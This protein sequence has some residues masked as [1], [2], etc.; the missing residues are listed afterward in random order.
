MSSTLFKDEPHEYW[1]GGYDTIS[2]MQIGV[3][4]IDLYL[5]GVS[6][7]KGKR[8]L[9]KGLI[10]RLHQEF[11]VS[12][13]ELEHHDVWQSTR[14]GVAVI[15]NESAHVQRVLQKVV[16]WIEENRPDVSVVDYGIEV[17]H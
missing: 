8:S 4:I 14:L 7:L 5:P 17:I 16:R 13:A 2:G 9:L 3:C 15:A 1:Q 10:A 11:N 6:S 12:C